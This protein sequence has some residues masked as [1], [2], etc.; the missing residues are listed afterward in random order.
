[1][2]AYHELYVGKLTFFCMRYILQMKQ[3]LVKVKTGHCLTRLNKPAC[4]IW[5]FFGNVQF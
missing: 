5:S 3:N 4:G 2:V 1:M